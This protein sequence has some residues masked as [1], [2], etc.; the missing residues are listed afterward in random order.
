M[1]LPANPLQGLATWYGP[2]FHGKR[3]ASG[4]R[5]NMNALTAAHRTLPFGTMVRVT[6]LRNK[7]DVVVRITDRGP[8]G[9]GRII[10]LSKRAATQ[11]GMLRAGVV[12]VELRVLRLG[13]NCRT[14]H[15]RTTCRPS[16]HFPGSAGGD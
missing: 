8:F 1:P 4:E 11:L 10:D 12:P 2:A 13:K 3:T 16:R 9:P 14:F 7:R 6:N 5:Y 15:G